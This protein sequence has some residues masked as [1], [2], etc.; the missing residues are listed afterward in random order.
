MSTKKQIYVVLAV[1]LL[2]IIGLAIS[3]IKKPEVNLSTSQ[4]AGESV[5]TENDITYLGTMR[6][7]QSGV[8]T[9]GAYGGLTGRRV[10]GQLRL[11]LYSSGFSGNRLYELAPTTTF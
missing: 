1:G 9:V 4:A 11:F 10:N 8:D 2:V 3:K 7:P 5:I 6:M